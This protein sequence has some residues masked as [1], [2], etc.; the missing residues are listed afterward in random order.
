[1]DE[2]EAATWPSQRLPRGQ[3][4][5]CHVA[6]PKAATWRLSGHE[7]FWGKFELHST[8]I[9]PETSYQQIFAYTIRL[10]VGLV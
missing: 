4:R 8:E 9:E 7:I 6:K 2:P 3:A 1:V 10:K 5:G